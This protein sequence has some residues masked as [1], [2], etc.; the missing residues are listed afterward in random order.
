MLPG[1]LLL[2]F[3]QIERSLRLDYPFHPVEDIDITNETAPNLRIINDVLTNAG[4]PIWN[5]IMYYLNDH[6]PVVSKV[7]QWK[8]RKKLDTI[9]RKYFSGERNEENFKIYKSYRLFLYKR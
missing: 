1:D 7:L 2:C 3:L 5:L 6:Y 4:L 9:N 8:Y